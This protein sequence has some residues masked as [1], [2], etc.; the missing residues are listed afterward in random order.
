MWPS[1]FLWPVISVA[2]ATV[3]G[4]LETIVVTGTRQETPLLETPVATEVI[5]G[6][7]LRAIGAENAAEALATHPGVQ[8]ERSFNGTTVQ[9]QGLSASRVL[10]LI[11]GQRQTGKVGEAIDLSRIAAERIERIEIVKGAASALYGADAVGGVI[12]V[13][14]KRAKRGVEARGH[15]VMGSRLNSDLSGEL[16]LGDDFGNLRLTAGWHRGRAYD[17]DASDPATN[18]SGF[19]EL[20]LAAKAELHLGSARVHA[21]GELNRRAL[22]G[23]DTNAAGAI[24]DRDN[25]TRTY[26]LTVGP[27]VPLDDTSRLQ[28][29]AHLSA[30]S[31]DYQ[32]DQRGSAALDQRQS[33]EERLYA[34]NVSYLTLFE[35]HALQVGVEGLAETLASPRLGGAAGDR[36]RASVYAQDEWRLFDDELPVIVV[37]GARVDVD[38]QFGGQLTPKLAIRV[39]PLPGWVLR[40]SYGRGFKAP[41]FRELLLDFEN[42]SVGYRVEGNPAL[43]PERSSSLQLSSEW[44]PLELL[45]LHLNVFRHEVDDII[46]TAAQASTAPGAPIRYLYVNV[47]QARLQG[48]EASVR[49]QPRRRWSLEASYT[50]LD[51]LDLSTGLPLADRPRHRIT[52]SVSLRL[53]TGTT[54]AARGAWTDARAIAQVAAAG[55]TAAPLTS[56]AYVNADLRL[57]QPLPGGLAAFVGVDNLFAAGDAQRLPLPPRTFYGGL[58]LVM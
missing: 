52:T 3:A 18:G 17:L 16:G 35:A 9:L 28:L 33:T 45:S 53:P 40:L 5:D 49:L 15:L 26:G 55:A 43:R 20:N 46:Q 7:R 39:D 10:V 1:V 51:A 44:T 2:S 14:T 25:R 54:V 56:P 8:L 42:P 58:N 22:T 31:D 30:F 12:N 11:D 37:P 6:E 57:E 48:L 32:L 41:T 38:S 34:L 27:D 19:D 24:F 4:A 50:F 36:Q 29:R 13:I 23:V 21:Q 47:A